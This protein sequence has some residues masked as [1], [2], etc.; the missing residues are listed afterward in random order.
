MNYTSQQLAQKVNA[1]IASLAFA[2]KPLELYSPITYTLS[3]GGKRIRPLLLMM[4]YNLYK[5]DVESVIDA[6]CAIEL[7][8]N[9]TL[10]HDDV[11]DHADLRRGMPTVHKKW[12]SNPAILSGDTMLVLAYQLVSHVP[13]CDLRSIYDIFSSTAIEIAEGQ[14]YDMEFETRWDVTEQEYIEMIRLKTSV[15]LAA[16]LKIGGILGGADKADLDA[17][18][19]L[20]E[21]VGLAFQVQ[22]DLLDVYGD[23]ATFGKNIGGDILCNKKTFL[24][25]QALARA[26]EAHTRHLNHWLH[27]SGF[28]AQEK[29]DGVRSLYDTL[30]IKEVSEAKIDNLFKEGERYLEALSVASDRKQELRHFISSLMNRET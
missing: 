22:D 10:L 7:Y 15:L 27:G 30:H 24:L 4:A 2:R 9:H 8:H 12:G 11:M 18:Y 1:R 28:T 16:S 23:P 29:I 25:I 6:A 14:Q 21:C 3:Q 17:L 19:H 20:G 26:D 13:D 5:E